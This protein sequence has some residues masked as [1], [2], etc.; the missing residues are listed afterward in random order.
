MSD[1]EYVLKRVFRLLTEDLPDANIVS[2]VYGF[3][4]EMAEDIGLNLHWEKD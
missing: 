2:N 4:S 1:L 3:V